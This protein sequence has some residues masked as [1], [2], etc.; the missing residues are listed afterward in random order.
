MN[1]GGRVAP[2]DRVAMEAKRQRRGMP[3]LIAGTILLGLTVVVMSGNIRSGD[4][5]IA[6]FMAWTAAIRGGTLGP[7]LIEVAMGLAGLTLTLTLATVFTGSRGSDSVADKAEALNFGTLTFIVGCVAA[8]ICWS[9]TLISI[10]R[11]SVGWWTTSLIGAIALFCGVLAGLFNPAR[12]RGAANLASARARKAR[13]TD[14]RRVRWADH[15]CVVSTHPVRLREVIRAQPF[16]WCF[17]MAAVLLAVTSVLRNA[18]DEQVLLRSELAALLTFFAVSGVTLMAVR[19]F[20][21]GRDLRDGWWPI[22]CLGLGFLLLLIPI[23]MCFAAN[24]S[25]TGRADLLYVFSVAGPFVGWLIT[26]N[27]D[28]YRDY[29]VAKLIERELMENRAIESQVQAL[30][31][32]RMR[33]RSS[34]RRSPSRRAGFSRSWSPRRSRVTPTGSAGSPG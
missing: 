14:V 25:F 28:W 10:D 1:R 17:T 21:V 18:P 13:I 31:A 4:R 19:S 5:A 24:R 23:P 29:V 30:S 27:L 15:R 26:R 3:S 8:T 16:G 12:S 11:D 20:S 22:S 32:L 7:H 2:V 9:L 33:A 34:R 6:D